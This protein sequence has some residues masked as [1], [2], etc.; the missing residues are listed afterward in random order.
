M[1]LF[2][3]MYWCCR[4]PV[5]EFKDVKIWDAEHPEHLQ[6]IDEFNKVCYRYGVSTNMYEFAVPIKNKRLI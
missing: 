2:E 4:P 5:E 6:F 3:W 1:K